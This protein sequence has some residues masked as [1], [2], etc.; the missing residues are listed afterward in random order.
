MPIITITLPKRYA[1][2][3]GD[4]PSAKAVEV[5]LQS[6]THGIPPYIPAVLK[7]DTEQVGVY[8]SRV[9]EARLKFGYSGN[10]GDMPFGQYVTGLVMAG[11]R[12]RDEIDDSEKQAE[13]A[14]TR[15]ELLLDGIGKKRLEQI[16]MLGSMLDA[17]RSGRILLA[18]G[19]TGVG[20][21]LCIAAAALECTRL[22]PDSRVLVGAP[23]FSVMEHLV[24]EFDKLAK[25]HRVPPRVCL[26][27]RGEYVSS[28]S[29]AE[30]LEG[31]EE[32]PD[33]KKAQKWLDQEGPCS[34]SFGARWLVD[35]LERAAPDFPAHE[36]VLG[37][38]ANDKDDEGYLAYRKQFD[39]AE[40]ARIVL[41]TH[42]M[43]AFDLLTRFIATSEHKLDDAEIK[44]LR[45]AEESAGRKAPP[46]YILD[47]P[48]R[49]RHEKDGDGFIPS[50]DF[51][52]ID[53]AHELESNIARSLGS[54][55][56][57]FTLQHACRQIAAL[58]PAAE[59]AA[60]A[61]VK[62]WR[63]LIEHGNGVGDRLYLS[64]V[65]RDEEY[66]PLLQSM[67]RLLKGVQAITQSAP[68]SKALKSA[69]ARRILDHI[70][71]NQQ[72][73]TRILKPEGP[74]PM[75]S[76]S[77]TPVRRYPQ[78][79]C[80]EA[81]V[82]RYLD[83]FWRGI[84]AGCAVS[85]TLYLPVSKS[86]VSPH[87]I[88]SVLAVPPDKMMTMSPQS[89]FWTRAPVTVYTPEKT[90]PD[91]SLDRMWLQPLQRSR[92]LKLTIAEQEKW[93]KKWKNELADALVRIVRGAK[94]GT[95]VLL[96]SYQD[97]ADIAQMM[98]SNNAS[99]EKRL[100]VASRDLAIRQQ[101]ERFLD[102]AVKNEKPI[103]LA[104]G[105]AWTG[106]D[107]NV[108][109]IE[110]KKDFILTD[111]VLAKLPFGTNNTSTHH[112]RLE[113]NN[114]WSRMAEMYATAIKAKQGIGRLVRKEGVSDRRLFVLDSRI[115]DPS[116]RG[117]VQPVL[118][119]LENYPNHEKFTSP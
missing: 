67:T 16:S 39:R 59:D 64:A 61:V 13:R 93:E 69:K 96:T 66:R 41:A 85:A 24:A 42:S 2:M 92:R 22:N 103:W 7:G 27:G 9:S 81:S 106:L 14:Q 102:V 77:F 99:L 26:L 28:I 31:D 105:A 23:T 50:Y 84:K 100:I 20:K 32:L 117:Y 104:T 89:P 111:L 88:A 82:A 114:A 87:Y 112:A 1:S 21:S 48:H 119:M 57:V 10:R 109:E 97:A 80:G 76:L 107:I 18:E 86:E 3:L 19:S 44:R 113:R 83:F 49:L 78:L 4:Q 79:L 5:A 72:T 63:E 37:K 8:L 47:N 70:R 91:R 45:V 40:D 73:L 25:H 95:L 65:L 6:L 56:S 34:N 51:A 115:H 60:G 62:A 90:P 17:M 98:V 74:P 55:V 36:V 71:E 94:G 116:M 118:D 12:G 75:V 101:R 33:R 58:S 30:L 38:S 52:L 54:E 46:R 108:K 35:D 29:L 11:L 15:A 53:E 43:I 68:R 110:A